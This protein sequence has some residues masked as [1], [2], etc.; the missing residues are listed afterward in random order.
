MDYKRIHI[1]RIQKV[2]QEQNENTYNDRNH[3]K[4]PTEI[5]ELKNTI[6]ELE[7]LVESFDN[8]VDQANE[9]ISN[10]EGK[11]FEII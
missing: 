1:D 8:R 7:I 6:I 11:S 2:I 9:I 10:W 5:L 4:E 3:K